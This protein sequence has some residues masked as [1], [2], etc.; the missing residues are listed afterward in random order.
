MHL[1][2]NNS[3]MQPTQ[4]GLWVNLVYISSRCVYKHC[5]PPMPLVFAMKCCTKMLCPLPHNHY[6]LKLAFFTN[7]LASPPHLYMS[8][9]FTH[10]LPTIVCVMLMSIAFFYFCYLLR[11]FV[12]PFWLVCVHIFVWLVFVSFRYFV[13]GIICLIFFFNFLKKFL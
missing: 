4:Y 3:S 7:M 12:T 2:G 5:F 1:V 8:H 9:L 11:F 6:S 13:C 10:C